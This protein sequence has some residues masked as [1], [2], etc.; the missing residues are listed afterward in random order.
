MER[1]KGAR[2]IHAQQM[3]ERQT[4]IQLLGGQEG[5]GR[6]RQA[7]R[8]GGGGRGSGGGTVL[9]HTQ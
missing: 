9:T 7:G 6:H 2:V 1:K 5:V 3:K 8:Q 4:W